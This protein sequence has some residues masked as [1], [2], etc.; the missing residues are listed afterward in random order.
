MASKIEQNIWQN[1]NNIRVANQI[2]VINLLKQNPMSCSML[3]Q[4][5]AL[6][7]TAVEKIVDELYEKKLL[8][9]EIYEN[10][11]RKKGRRPILYKLNNKLGVVGAIDLS[12]RDI[13][14][15]L[16]DIS[17]RILINDYIYNVIYI[18]KKIIDEIIDKI[19]KM[20]Q[21]KVVKN[22]ELLT[23]CISSP[24][25]I[26]KKTSRYV[27]APR[28]KNYKNLDPRKLLSDAFNVDV[29]MYNDVNMG[30]VGEK[31]F[32]YLLNKE[33][34]NSCFVHIDI[35]VGSSLFL[36]G[37][38]YEGSYGFAGE[39]PD[40]NIIDD[41]SKNAYKNR[42]YS[43]TDIFINILKN[44]KNVPDHPFH[45]KNTLKIEEVCNLF[46]S[47]DKIVCEVVEESAK[48]N[49]LQLLNVANLLDL[50]YIVLEGTI[51]S[52]G[53]KYK[54][55][56]NKYYKTYDNNHNNAKLV[57]STLDNEAILLGVIY[58]AIN[59]FFI[60]Q[61]QEL[62]AKRTNNSNYDV[63]EYFGINV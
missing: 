49:A 5:L 58:Q 16:A 22:M 1:Q 28:I 7:N 47:N 36:N 63:N 11:T 10:N 29:F 9:N 2:K 12:G 61:F 21:D 43:I 33:F 52:F 59:M 34:E 17:N 19:K 24:G 45:G 53:E 3:A 14:I 48:Y 31:H 44:V 30:L 56:L 27:Y 42:Y 26:D 40:Y 51:L 57:Y 32:G 18:D 13:K 41:I 15:C 35:T 46:Y 60:K 50:E 4:K 54:N 25:K 37:Q 38:M 62:V 6:S 39:I 55:L 23:I 20:L 8:V